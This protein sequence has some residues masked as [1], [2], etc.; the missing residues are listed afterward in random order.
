MTRSSPLIRD[1]A[2]VLRRAKIVEDAEAEK[3]DAVVCAGLDGEPMFP[4]NL[5]G[6]CADCHDPIQW[7]PHAPKAPPKICLRCGLIRAEASRCT[8]P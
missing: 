1:L 3:A 6:E 7:R 4:D 8:P 2:A 5:T